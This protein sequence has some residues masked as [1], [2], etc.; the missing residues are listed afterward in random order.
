LFAT[1]KLR[2][3]YLKNSL[4]RALKFHY[5]KKDLPKF[6]CHISYNMQNTQKQEK[7]TSIGPKMSYFTGIHDSLSVSRKIIEL[8]IK[9]L[10]ILP[11]F[12]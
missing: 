12:A 3:L 7:T 10:E 8:P 11:A 9:N 4:K 2:K 5:Y 6:L 1:A